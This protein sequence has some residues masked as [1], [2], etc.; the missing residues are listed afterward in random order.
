MPSRLTLS[1]AQ[2]FT[3]FSEREQNRTVNLSGS[4]VDPDPHDFR[5]PKSGSGSI[6][7]YTDPDPSIIKQ[8]KKEKPLFLRYCFVTS[9]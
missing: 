4:V 5:H 8:T 7:I 1:Q 9:L 6:N 2:D 3:I